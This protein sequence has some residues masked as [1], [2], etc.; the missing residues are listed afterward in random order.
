MTLDDDCLCN[1]FVLYKVIGRSVIVSAM[2]TQ[3]LC[4]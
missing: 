2:E 1:A 3:I 4:C